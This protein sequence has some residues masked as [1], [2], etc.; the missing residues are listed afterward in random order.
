MT[1]LGQFYSF[2]SFNFP[3]HYIAHANFLG[4]LIVPSSDLQRKDS[5]FKM[6][7]G[8]ASHPNGGAQAVSFES[9]NYPG[10]YLRHFQ[11]R[12]HL[13]TSDG[14][15][16]FKDDA[17]FWLEAGNAKPSDVVYSSF[18]SFN[19]PSRFIRHRNFDLWVEGGDDDPF[20][21]DSTFKI[22]SP[23]WTPAV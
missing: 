3:D 10:Y 2:Q 13:Q 17:T 7:E 16:G 12:I 21:S 22:M 20:K 8:L 19:F 4:E 1:T 5:T 23:L 18:R 6:I 15:E 14:T 9:F 11:F